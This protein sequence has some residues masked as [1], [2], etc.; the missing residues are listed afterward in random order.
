IADVYR[1]F[2]KLIPHT[3]AVLL[4][5]TP[6]DRVLLDAQHMWNESK[7]CAKF[8]S[9]WPLSMLAFTSAAHLLSMRMLLSTKAAKV[10]DEDTKMGEE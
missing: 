7:L 3:P 1:Q 2:D 9:S 10:I 6:A 8:M 5:D 4:N